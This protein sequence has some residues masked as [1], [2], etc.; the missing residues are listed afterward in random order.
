[1]RLTILLSGVLAL[2]SGVL[3]DWCDG[4][5]RIE[6]RSCPGGRDL[7]CCNNVPGSGQVSQF[8]I[9]RGDCQG[10]GGSCGDGGEPRCCIN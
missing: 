8:Q 6:G 5:V 2:T 1:M 9:W 10:T 4:G 3:A 7:F